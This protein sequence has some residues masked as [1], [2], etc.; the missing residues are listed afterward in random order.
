MAEYTVNINTLFMPLIH[1]FFFQIL[2]RKPT[3]VNRIKHVFQGFAKNDEFIFHQR[4]LRKIKKNI[5]DNR[6]NGIAEAN[7]VGLTPFAAETFAI[8]HNFI[9]TSENISSNRLCRTVNFG[10]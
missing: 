8:S 7:S 10:R 6:E 9:A 5:F 1:F 2:E 3:F 4:R